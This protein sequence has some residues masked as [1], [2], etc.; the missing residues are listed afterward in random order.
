P[1][2]LPGLPQLSPEEV[3]RLKEQQ[4]LVSAQLEELKQTCD[5]VQ[6]VMQTLPQTVQQQ[7]EKAAVAAQEALHGQ[8][9]QEV[10]RV[11]QALIQLEELKQTREWM[12]SVVQALLQTMQQQVEKA[13]VAAQ[14]ALHEHGDKEVARVQQAVVQLE[15]LQQTREWVQSVVQSLPHTVQQQVAQAA[16][17]A[18]EALHIHGDQEIARV[19][20]EIAEF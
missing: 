11:Q 10:A 16:A 18:Q 3:T 13:A 5:W 14:E 17:A 1:E 7:V 6:S 19:Q 2:P 4:G 12:Q 9:D 8:A 15:E 20:K